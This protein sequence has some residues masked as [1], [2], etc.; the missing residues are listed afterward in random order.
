M[1]LRVDSPVTRGSEC[2]E[3]SEWPMVA[4]GLRRGSQAESLL[5][6]AAMCDRC[7]PLLR[8]STSD[9]DED[10]TA[11]EEAM[12]A[13]LKSSQP[14]WQRRMAA[15]IVES[16]QRPG[17]AAWIRERLAPPLVRKWA[18]AAGLTLLAGA[19]SWELWCIRQRPIDALLATAYT[20][21]R[22]FELRI[23]S[24]A[25][26]PVRL[27]RGSGSDS[28]LERP[29]ALLEGQARIARGLSKQPDNASLLQAKARADLLEW[30][31]DAAIAA[32]ERARQGQPDS[33]SL[34]IDLASAYFQCAEAER[35]ESDYAGAVGLLNK[36][37]EA[38]PDDPVA[39]FNRA[40]I[41]QRMR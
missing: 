4:A 19:S 27:A 7:G 16:Q 1:R 39:L 40:I 29:P 15:K 14:V 13:E 5:L 22:T 38:K 33:P 37:L 18:Y 36:A 21:Q 10:V 8:Q 30:S 32:L 9:F 12:L 35:R 24:A 25:Y 23:P 26:A 11:E 6:H 20:E 34:M 2:P 31:Y 28:R 41:Y 17:I 3:H